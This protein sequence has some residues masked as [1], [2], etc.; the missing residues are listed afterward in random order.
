MNSKE[1]IDAVVN[2]E[3]PDRVPVGPLLDHFAATY[4]GYT[5]AQIMQDGDKRIKAVLKTMKE[6]GPWDI[7]FAADTA[8]AY[9][10]KKGVPVRIQLPGKELP[11]N[12]IHQFEEIE[13]LEPEDYDFLIEKGFI[14]FFLDINKRLYPE[15]KLIKNFKDALVCL[16]DLRKHRKMIE[17]SGSELACSFIIPGPVFEYFSLGRGLVKASLDIFDHPQKIKNAGK[18]WTKAFTRLAIM[19][20]RIVGSK[21]IFIGMSRSSPSLISPKHFETF[22]LPELEY[23]VNKIV[24]AGLTPLLHLDTDWTKNFHFFK[25]FPKKKCILELDSF[26]NIFKAKDILGDHMCI[27]GDVPATLQAHGTKDEVLS[28]CKKLIRE[29]GKGGGFILSSGCSIPFNAK[30]ENVRAM[31]EA[32]D[33][34]GIY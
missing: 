27:M 25:R 1:R 19:V 7:T 15:E 16:K 23:M 29:V 14:K 4:S 32:V 9:V 33:K 31:R 21:R 3:V 28:Y 18:I 26:S 24:D 30:P 13:F 34:W 12:D 5:T 20:T 22:V 10:L 2:L 11:D 6:L 17:A 8:N